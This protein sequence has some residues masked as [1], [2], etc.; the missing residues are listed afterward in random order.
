MPKPPKPTKVPIA[1]VSTGT[2]ARYCLVSPQT[3]QN[4]IQSRGLPAQ[5]T[6]GGQYRIRVEELR[7]FMIQHGMSVAELDRDLY[8]SQQLHCWEFFAATPAHSA[9]ADQCQACVVYRC[10]ALRCHELRQHVDHQKI[11]CAKACGECEY[12]QAQENKA[13]NRE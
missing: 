6:G 7:T 4:W 13:R 11:H 1:A 10:Q 12:Y 5:R 3:I 9:H 8:G 2:A